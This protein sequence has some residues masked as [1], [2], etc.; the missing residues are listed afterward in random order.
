MPYVKSFKSFNT[1]NSKE[2]KKIEEQDTGLSLGGTDP[3]FKSQQDEIKNLRTTINKLENDIL[4]KKNELNNKVIALEN[5]VK[6][7]ADQELAL[8][9][10]NSNQ[11]EEEEPATPEGTVNVGQ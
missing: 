1:A 11:E 9:N 6:I 10:Q 4:Q 7:K 8:R 3:A 2:T 5:A